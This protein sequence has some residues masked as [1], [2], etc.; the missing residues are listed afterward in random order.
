MPHPNEAML[1]AYADDELETFARREV[2]VHLEGC[3]LC[4]HALRDLRDAMEALRV[5]T[6]LVDSG[7]PVAWRSG[8]VWRPRPASRHA[9][10]ESPVPGLAPT[11]DNERKVHPLTPALARP[12]MRPLVRR[13]APLR[14]AATLMLVVGGAAAAMTAPQWRRVLGDVRAGNS[15]PPSVVTPEA[16]TMP[17][18]ARATRA[19]VSVVPSGDKAIVAL[20]GG[21]GA[22]D[23]RVI[24]RTS[25]RVDVQVTVTSAANAEEMPHFVSGEGRLDVQLAVTSSMIV[26]EV[27]A[28]LH[29]AQ[30]T[31]DG[32]A[33][34]SVRRGVI[35]PARAAAE[36]VSLA[37]NP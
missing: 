20:S 32:R 7:E 23:R 21:E 5:E 24:V 31:F 22:S 27:P 1:I 13:I 11:V 14:W 8:P 35:S 19:A 2:H 9:P 28:T 26:V 15:P 6:A 36:G 3:G 10:R 17:T 29:V 25:D 37:A 18:V 16:S 12:L 34:V 33:V 30:V 4:R